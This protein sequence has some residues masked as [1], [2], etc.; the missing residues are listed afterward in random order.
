M[1]QECRKS[2]SAEKR[3]TSSSETRTKVGTRRIKIFKVPQQEV[4]KAL[5]ILPLCAQENRDELST[6]TL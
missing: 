2:I 5:I 6:E 1:S 3:V 4:R